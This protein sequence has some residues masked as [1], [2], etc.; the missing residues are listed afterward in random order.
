MT[1]DFFMELVVVALISMAATVI[2]M[3]FFTYRDVE[4]FHVKTKTTC[5]RIDSDFECYERYSGESEEEIE[6][7]GK[8]LEERRGKNGN[9]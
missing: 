7:I 8:L 5:Y 9:N 3:R 4:L 2:A 6:N 1:K